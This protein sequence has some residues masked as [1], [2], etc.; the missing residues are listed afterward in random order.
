MASLSVNSP[1]CKAI[2]HTCNN[3]VISLSSGACSTI[4][5]LP[6]MH[7]TQ[8]RMPKMLSLSFSMMCASTALQGMDGKS[9]YATRCLHC[10]S[11]SLAG[12]MLQYLPYF[13]GKLLCCWAKGIPDNDAQ[14][15]ERGDKH[16]RSE[17][18]CCKICNLSHHHSQHPRPPERLHKI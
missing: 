10:H 7:S 16:G 4:V 9:S 3:E 13:W 8:P 12:T 15:S 1:G 2:F 5:R 14:R 11:L 6:T 17:C 18:I